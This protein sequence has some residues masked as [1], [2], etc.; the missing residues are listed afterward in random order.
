VCLDELVL[1]GQTDLVAVM[2][3]RLIKLGQ[4][5]KV[6]H[7][8]HKCIAFPAADTGCPKMLVAKY[9]FTSAR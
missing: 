6:C 7:I 5:I 8:D 3:T 9:L 2:L 1:L 4:G